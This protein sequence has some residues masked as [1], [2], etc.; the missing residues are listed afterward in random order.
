MIGNRYLSFICLILSSLFAAGQEKQVCFTYDDIPVTELSFKNDDFRKKVTADLLSGLSKHKIPAIG[1]V[2]ESKLYSH[3]IKDPVDGRLQKWDTPL[4]IS[5]MEKPD[6]LQVRLLTDWLK[7]GM[8]IGNHTFSHMGYHRVDSKI[9]FEDIIKGGKISGK[10]AEQYDKS[11]K[12]FRHP[13]LEFGIGKESADSLTRFLKNHNYES[14]PVTINNQDWIFAYAYDS[15]MIHKDTALMKQIGQVYL[16]F[17]E[18]KLKYAE[19][20]SMKLFGRII[21]QSLCLHANGLEADYVDELA[22]IYEKN[23]YEFVTLDEIL[24]DEAYLTPITVFGAKGMY[25]WLDYWAI[26]K[27]K[28]EDFFNEPQPSEYIMKLAKVK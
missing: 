6:T 12:Y 10:I 27:G 24:T 20:Q 1:F 3:E 5:E 18:I 21:K 15:A 7:S 26:S 4:K 13:C 28:G 16:E 17:A 9:Y 11:L 23:N 14:A 8:E 25:S 19:E 22:G 2:R